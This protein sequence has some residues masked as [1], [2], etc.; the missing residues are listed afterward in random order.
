MINT[1]R[2][3]QVTEKRLWQ[4][5]YILMVKGSRFRLLLGVWSDWNGM[6][7]WKSP[8]GHRNGNMRRNDRDSL[9]SSYLILNLPLSGTARV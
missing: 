4:R 8:I 7:L 1:S 9:H 2:R 3:H 6:R 5:E